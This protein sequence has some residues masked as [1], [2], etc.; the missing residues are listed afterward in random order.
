VNA[1]F[2]KPE[3]RG[4]I[5]GHLRLLCAPDSR[6]VSSLR[7][8]SFRAPIH[9]S[10]PHWEGNTLVLNVVNPT[11][12]L[13]EDDRV[14]QEA[15]VARGAS[16]VLT[17]PGASRAH[18]VRQGW[19]AMEQKFTVENGGSLE[20]LPE[21]FIPQSGACYRQSTLLKVEEGGEL[22]YFES[23]APGRTA[24]GEVFQYRWLG[25]RTD[26]HI[27]DTHAARERLRMEPGTP[28][29]RALAGHFPTAYYASAYGVS[30]RFGNNTSVLQSIH[31]LHG[32]ESWV[33][34]SPL[35][36][37]HGLG[38]RIVSQNATSM[39]DTLAKL[40]RILHAAMGR[41]PPDLRRT[42]GR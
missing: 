8:Q 35:A 15:T 42:A 10:K 3:F 31:A 4:G 40:R 27:G 14:T 19:A 22:L 18:R 38:V 1:G 36:H 13:L 33:G 41:T 9:L 5:Q 34:A 30:P 12:G 21:I 20:V 24:S 2:D 32:G 6:G 25:W 16:L 37:P 23:L 39:R 29:M 26:L 11:A 17:M 28:P 7:E